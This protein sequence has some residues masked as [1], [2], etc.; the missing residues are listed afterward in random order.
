VQN[1]ALAGHLSI[2]PSSRIGQLGGAGIID[3]ME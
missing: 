3:P 1:C 2:V